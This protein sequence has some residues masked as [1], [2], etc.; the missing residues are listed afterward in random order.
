MVEPP[1]G[2]RKG[3]ADAWLS[4]ALGVAGFPEPHLGRG[5]ALVAGLLDGAGPHCNLVERAAGEQHL[6]AGRAH[7]DAA[8]P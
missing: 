1:E 6:G 4:A 3:I 2:A 8:S 5:R 7:R